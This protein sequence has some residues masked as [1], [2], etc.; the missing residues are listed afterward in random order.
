[1]Y[2][3]R[4]YRRCDAQFCNGKKRIEELEQENAALKEELAEL[5]KPKTAPEKTTAK[6]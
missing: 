3:T 5:A 4:D 1:M 6:K 2:H